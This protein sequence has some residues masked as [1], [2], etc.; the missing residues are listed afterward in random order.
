MPSCMPLPQNF[1][2]PF[3]AEASA[4]CSHVWAA[5]PESLLHMLVLSFWQ[6]KVLAFF[7]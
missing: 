7:G 5:W 2:I 4:E 3:I 1:S 6:R